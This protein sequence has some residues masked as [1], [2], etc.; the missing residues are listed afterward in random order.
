MPSEAAC[1]GRF[2]FVQVFR[3][4]VWRS[5]VAAHVAA[6]VDLVAAIGEASVVVA[7]AATVVV[8]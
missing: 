3:A 6:A 8:S 7:V 2:Y 4:G 5:A 1:A